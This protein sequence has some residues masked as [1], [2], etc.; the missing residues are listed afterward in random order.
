MYYKEDIIIDGNVSE[1]LFFNV[2]NY[3]QDIILAFHPEF[4]K[5][6]VKVQGFSNPRQIAKN[7]GTGFSAGVDSFSTIMTIWNG[8]LMKTIRYHLY[9]FSM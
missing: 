8:S 6:N 3:V 1:R 4:R 7:V 5:A 2:K 9:S